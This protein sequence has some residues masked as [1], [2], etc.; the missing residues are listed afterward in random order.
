MFNIYYNKSSNR[1]KEALEFAV[2]CIN[3]GIPMDKLSDEEFDKT[4]EEYRKQ[5]NNEISKV[6]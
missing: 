6:G 1:Q 2:Y 4:L 5:V 3:N